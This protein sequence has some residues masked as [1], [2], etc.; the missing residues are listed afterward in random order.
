MQ[1]LE[2][3][4]RNSSIEEITYL[5]K[6]LNDYIVPLDKEKIIWLNLDSNDFTNFLE[7]NYKD[8]DKNIVWYNSQ[9]YN[10]LGMKYLSF[11][12]I[13]PGYNYLIGVIPNN[14]DKFTIIAY[15]CYSKN[16]F[17]EVG[18]KKAVNWLQTIETN[19]FY[20]K[21]GLFKMINEL[22]YNYID[23]SKD[24]IT[25]DEFDDGIL[26]HTIKRIKDALVN[27]GYQG[28]FYINTEIPKEYI[29]KIKE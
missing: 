1:E 16:R 6:W 9:L 22:L 2:N 23:Q 13:I 29:K 3:I 14:I 7:E 11:G 12:N 21:K 27:Q 18:Q 17:F 28:E 25:T 19:A 5:K 4:I 26:C 24:F 8:D 15:A 10:V 20:K